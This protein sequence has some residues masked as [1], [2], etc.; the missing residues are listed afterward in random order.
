MVSAEMKG[1]APVQG[2]KSWERLRSWDKLQERIWD[3]DPA[4]MGNKIIRSTRPLIFRNIFIKT[5][6]KHIFFSWYFIQREVLE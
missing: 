5:H 4:A 6:C 2:H 3:N 1:M